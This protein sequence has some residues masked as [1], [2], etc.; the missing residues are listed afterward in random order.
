[1]LLH[2]EFLAKQVQIV[3]LKMVQ[4]PIQHYE[5]Y[6]TVFFTLMCTYLLF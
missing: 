1:M 6:R 3:H 2:M 4:Q 5:G